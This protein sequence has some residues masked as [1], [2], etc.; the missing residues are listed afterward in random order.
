MFISPTSSYTNCSKYCNLNYTKCIPKI[1]FECFK[2]NASTSL[3]WY[4]VTFTDSMASIFI[5]KCLDADVVRQR[6]PLS[7]YVFILAIEI[8]ANK[9]RYDKNIKGITFDNKIIKISLLAG[10]LHNPHNTRPKINWICS[11]L[12]NKFSLCLGLII[13]I[14]MTQSNYLRK[15]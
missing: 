3:H 11:K 5:P 14:E 8:L 4:C 12:L 1:P 13:N 7:V 9:I 10:V 15:P 2:T 6:R